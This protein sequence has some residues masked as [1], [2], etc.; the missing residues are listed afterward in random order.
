MS[1]EL[2]PQDLYRN[3]A[4]FANPRRVDLEQ[5]YTDGLIPTQF[6]PEEF[7]D[8]VHAACL[9]E[10]QIDPNF[11]NTQMPDGHRP[12]YNGHFSPYQNEINDRLMSTGVFNACRN[13][14]DRYGIHIQDPG[15]EILHDEALEALRV[16]N[17]RIIAPFAK[18]PDTIAPCLEYLAGRVGDA[19]VVA[20][21]S[22]LDVISSE[23]ARSTGMRVLNQWDILSCISLDALKD[24]RYVPDTIS[25]IKT[26]KGGT[27]YAGM[28]VQA[29]LGNLDS[30]L[31]GFHDTDI[32]NAGPREGRGSKDQYLALDHLG[33]GLAHPIG[34]EMLSLQIGRTGP[35]RNNFSWHGEVQNHLQEDTPPDVRTLA[36][37]LTGIIWPLTGE[38]IIKGSALAKIPIPMDMKIETMLNVAVAGMEL[39]KGT[40]AA[41]QVANLNSKDESG[42]AGVEREWGMIYGCEQGLNRYLRFVKETGHM[43]HEWDADV[44][45]YYNLLY[46]HRSGRTATDPD[47]H[48]HARKMAKVNEGLL[49]PSINQLTLSGAVDLEKVKNLL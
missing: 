26:T 32:T 34:S 28:I 27:M 21:D 13:G 8:V 36:H 5:A 11:V 22:G 37:Y 7:P 35:G 48:N 41:W 42:D 47:V 49:M 45:G 29:A 23:R 30:G 15:A 33:I 1:T 14:S 12:S 39:R 9:P 44:I 4:E 19:N 18:E 16:N 10:G 17:L 31:I 25:Q 2:P 43:P 24:L 3:V 40:R 20:I 38:R 6:P 46:G